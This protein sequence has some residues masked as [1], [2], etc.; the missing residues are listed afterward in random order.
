[1][2]F[3]KIKCFFSLK[4]AVNIP[5]L[6]GELLKG[7]IALITGGTSGIGYAIADAF[8]RNGADVI[9]TG[10][11]QDKIDKA[12]EAL[13]KRNP[14]NKAFGSVLNNCDIKG[15]P[16]VIERVKNLRGS[17]DILVNNAGVIN[18]TNFYNAQELDY[19]NVLDTNL[20]GAYFISKYFSEYMRENKIQGNILN[21]SSSSALRPA[22]TPY[23]LAKWGIRGLTLGLAKELSQYGIVVNA[24]APGPT[25]TSM[26]L[27]YGDKDISR[28][29][30]PSGRYVTAEE[31]ANLAVVLVSNLGK[32]V[33]GDTLYATG[34]CGN[35]TLDDW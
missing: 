15:M 14:K 21:V 4:Y 17:I 11:S 35:L 28:V 24:I 6:Y 5:V 3:R 34:G 10:R 33:N 30:S 9:I 31:I 32:M 18:K 22:T 13:N 26:L 20:K 2:L 27:A 12:C 23:H 16:D 8:M 25:A 19:D 29:A 7:R 1:M